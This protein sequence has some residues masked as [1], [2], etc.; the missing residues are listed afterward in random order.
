MVEKAWGMGIDLFTSRWIRKQRALVGWG[1]G[2]TLRGTLT[3]TL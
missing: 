3:P 1:Q 2:I